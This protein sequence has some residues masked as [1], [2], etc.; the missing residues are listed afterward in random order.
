MEKLAQKS[1]PTLNKVGTSMVWYTT[2]YQ[3]NY[4]WLS[5]QNLYLLYFLNKLLVYVDFIF[6]ELFWLKF[7]STN[8]YY[9]K[10]VSVKPI[11]KKTKFYKPVTSYL[12]S[13]GL[14][15]SLINIYYKSSLEIFQE[16]NEAKAPKTRKT[17]EEILVELKLSNL[18]FRIKK[19]N[20]FKKRRRTK[21]GH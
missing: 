1:L 15:F 17:N 9:T 13:L 19:K 7:Y 18:F 11:F 14:G 16:L 4:K 20:K 5:T 8:L 21:G 10:R 6:S 3:K 2:F 12:V